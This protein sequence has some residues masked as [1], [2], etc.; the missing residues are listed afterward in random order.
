M[1]EESS[2]K[3]VNPILTRY[4]RYAITMDKVFKGVNYKKKKIIKKEKEF[5]FKT[6]IGSNNYEK[7]KLLFSYKLKLGQKKI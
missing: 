3:K 1:T 7:F 4:S 6:S 2:N 5:N